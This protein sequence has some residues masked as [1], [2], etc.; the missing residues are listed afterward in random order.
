MNFILWVNV[1]MTLAHCGLIIALIG[2]IA[3]AFSASFE[4][5][6]TLSARSKEEKE[7]AKDIVKRSQDGSYWEPSVVLVNRLLFYGGLTLIS[8]GTL[9]QW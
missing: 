1:N 9:M 8:I 6:H 3:L 2:T 4:N 7:K 5:K